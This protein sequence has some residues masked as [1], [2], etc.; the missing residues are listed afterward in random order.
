MVRIDAASGLPSPLLFRRGPSTGNRLE[1]AAQ[2]QFSRTERARF[3]IPAGAGLTLT[4]GRLLDRT[5][6]PIEVPVALGERTDAA[7]QRW[8]TADVTLAPLAPGDYIIELTGD[9]KTVM[10]AIRVGR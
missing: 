4:A 8:L 5:G 9:A 6:T 10:T 2:A 1:P 3:E 7:G